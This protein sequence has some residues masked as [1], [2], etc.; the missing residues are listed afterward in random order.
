MVLHYDSRS[1]T[2]YRACVVSRGTLK[3]KE[4]FI[5]FVGSVLWLSRDY[6]SHKNGGTGLH[7]RSG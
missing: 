6:H 1:G 7:Q 4:D 2:F 5:T 3:K